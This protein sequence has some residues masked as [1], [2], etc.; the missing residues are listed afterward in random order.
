MSEE[1][2]SNTQ[3][4]AK[5]RG[6]PSMQIKWPEEEFTPKQLR[7]TLMDSNVNLSNVSVQLKINK[8]VEEGVLAK[9]GVSRTSI[10]RPTVVYKRVTKM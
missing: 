3:T 4:T 10:G 9:A 7:E 6:R 1:V 2:T 5:K 8:A